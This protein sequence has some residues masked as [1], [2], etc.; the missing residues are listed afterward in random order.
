M[1]EHKRL[2]WRCKNA[3]QAKDKATIYNSS[4][5]RKLRTA[6]L[7]AQP[8]CE[9]CISDGL[10]AG[11]KPF[12]YV[13][14]ACCVHHVVPIESAKTM[15]D[16]KRLAFDWNNLQ[17]LCIECHRKIHNDAGYHNKEVVKE[18]ETERQQRRKA[19]LIERFTGHTTTD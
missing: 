5:W 12:G 4:E 16:M 2:P 11:V 1:S 7:R 8:L 3:Q 10:A 6:K 13:R 14:S 9:K 18:R 17:S 15:A 19:R